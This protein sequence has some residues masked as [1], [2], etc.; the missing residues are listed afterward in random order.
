MFLSRPKASPIWFDTTRCAHLTA[1][2]LARYVAELP[3]EQ[4]NANGAGVAE[5][6]DARVSKTRG[7]KA[8]SVRFRFPALT[9]VY[10]RPDFPT[11]KHPFDRGSLGSMQPRHGRARTDLFKQSETQ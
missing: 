7:R 2:V 3:L 4:Y 8:V 9:C 6:A 11:A 5:Q 10:W 1:L